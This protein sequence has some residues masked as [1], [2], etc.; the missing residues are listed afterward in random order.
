MTSPVLTRPDASP[1]NSAAALARFG[2][3]GAAATTL[4]AL[5]AMVIGW[6]APAAPLSDDAFLAALRGSAVA[7]VAAKIAVVVGAGLLLQTWLRLN[8]HT[9]G[10]S[11]TQSRTLGWLAL[12]WTAPLLLAPAL[13][14]R[15]VFSYI[16]HSRLMPA[17]I[18]PYLFGTGALPTYLA[19]GADP[20]WASSPAP[21][22]PLWMGISSGVHAVTNAE[23]TA[24]LLAFRL[25]ALAG[26]ALMVWFL[27]R[28]A[29]AA[30]ADPG[31]AVWLATLNPLIV[32][33]FGTAAH[34]DALMVGLLV[35]GF[36]LVMTHRPLLGVLLIVA[37]GAIKSPALIALPF[38]GLVWAG[39]GA[40]WPRRIGA[41]AW[42]G[43]VTVAAF[44]VLGWATG[45]SQNW[46]VNLRTPAKVE[47]WLS[48]ST[49]VGKIIGAPVELLGWASGDAVLAT[50][51][52]LGAVAAL[53]VIAWL[54]FTPDRRTPL[55][56]FALALGVLV[57]LG[58]VIQPW[59]VL[60]VLP[61]L[62]AAGL[63][64]RENRWV[65]GL[66]LGLAVYTLAN[67]SATTAGFVAL[68]DS[69]AAAVSVAVM[70]A[71]VFAPPHARR[72]LLPDAPAAR[73]PAVVA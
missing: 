15:D 41:W 70:L 14:S 26:V 57:L 22:G 42:V 38:A 65:V 61:V 10:L 64:E 58:P 69:V 36:A 44:G 51:R 1:W 45:L 60:W 55:R 53:S 40:S 54:L 62:A 39:S 59:Y 11:V 37:A 73:T 23:P 2:L 19:D 17:G 67:V 30:G 47:T 24:A 9:A 50:T 7:S 35:A 13:F 20:L 27:P 46:L 8:R 25:L 32:F 28:L 12:V 63:T 31:R 21:Y 6:L 16:A 52:T 18:D 34:N 3:P 4:M 49:A 43:T 29:E 33:H 48:P 5:G 56:G 68:P 66:S 72:I 71:M